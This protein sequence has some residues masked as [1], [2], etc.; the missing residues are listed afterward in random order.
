MLIRAIS[1]QSWTSLQHPNYLQPKQRIKRKNK[2]YRKS[3]WLKG[4]KREKWKEDTR[5]RAMSG[6][7]SR[8]F[9]KK[10]GLFFVFEEFNWQDNGKKSKYMGGYT[11]TTPSLKSTSEERE[12]KGDYNRGK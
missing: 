3:E 4:G 10:G 2:K 12:R 11:P 7:E 1:I 5:L 8:I 6:G 9:R